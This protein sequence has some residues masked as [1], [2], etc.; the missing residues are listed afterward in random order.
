MQ[1]DIKTNNRA[2]AP[3]QRTQTPKRW[4]QRD[5]G[6]MGAVLAVSVLSIAYAIYISWYATGDSI[7]PKV[8][9]VPAALHAAR[10]FARKFTK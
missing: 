9:L 4:Y 10:I 5:D 7:V 3:G 8:L 6:I 1:S 2:A